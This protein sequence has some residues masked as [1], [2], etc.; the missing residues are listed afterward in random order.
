MYTVEKIVE[1][2]QLANLYE[3]EHRE[4]LDKYGDYE[5][6][7]ICNGIGA[8]FLPFTLRKFIN[9][10]NPSLEVVAVIHDVEY[11][12]S[13]GTSHSFNVSNARFAA[14]GIKVAAKAFAWYNPR[15]YLVMYQAK[16][17]A[18]YCQWF[19]Y[20]AWRACAKNRS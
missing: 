20:P 18:D 1:F 6:T 11:H 7:R 4:I 3:L 9:S 15:R 19:G 16:K 2:R 12:E 8:E 14:N 10:L 17:F 13:D 5:L